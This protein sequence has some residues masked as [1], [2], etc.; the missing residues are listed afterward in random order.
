MTFTDLGLDC[1]V[2][3]EDVTA[4]DRIDWLKLRQQGL[5]GSDAAATMS[6]SPWKSPF[7]LYVDKVDEINDEGQTERMLRGH[8]MEG[9]IARMFAE[10]VGATIVNAQPMVRSRRHPFMLFNLD[11]L[12]VTSDGELELLEAKN[13]GSFMAHEWADG[14]P[15][16][17]R[18]QV[19]HGLDVLQLKV[20]HLCALIGGNTFVHYRIEWSEEILA[21]I[22]KAEEKFW[23]EVQM[24]RPPEVDETDSTRDALAKHYARPTL[25]TVEVGPQMLALVD[26]R[27]SAKRT[28]DLAAQRV[29]RVENEMKLLIGD[30]EAA[31]VDGEIVATWKAQSRAEHVVKSST[32]RKLH[33]PERE[34]T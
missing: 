34:T 15:L 23:G 26:Q 3:C 20:G 10:E 11:R 14:P 29:T 16:H 7:A 12:V 28:L 18:I 2:V 6:L 5:G 1:D 8:Q 30:A 33:V 31:T 4:I 19:L 17:Y 25:E 21:G 22:I 24:K 27:T 9:T 32:F 13:V